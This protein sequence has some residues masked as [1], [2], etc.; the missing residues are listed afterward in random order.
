VLVVPRLDRCRRTVVVTESGSGTAAGIFI[1]RFPG[2]GDRQRISS[3]GGG[4]NAVWSPNSPELF[5]RRLSDGAMMTVSIRTTP[6]LSIGTPVVLFKNERYSR[7]IPSRGWDVAPDGRFL[8][9]K[10]K[11]SP[12]MSDTRSVIL[13]QNWTEELRETVPTR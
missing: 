7:I 13:V 2:L 10:E 11:T 6:V 8:M 12:A 5:Y 4:L 9:L 1:E 3:E